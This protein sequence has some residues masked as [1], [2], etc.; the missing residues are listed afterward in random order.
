MKTKQKSTTL[1]TRAANFCERARQHGHATIQIEWRRNREG[2]Q[3]VAL[4]NQREAMARTSGG[5]Y[6]KE[7][8]ALADCLRFLGRNE[9]EAR[10]IWKKGGMGLSAI[11]G[12]LAKLGF[13]LE[14]TVTGPKLDT[15]SI[16]LTKK[17]R[18][19]SKHVRD[20]IKAHILECVRNPETDKPFEDIKDACKRMADEFERVAGDEY[21]RRRIPND[22]DRFSDFLLGLPFSFEFYDKAIAEHLNSLGINPEGKEYPDEKARHLYHYLIF[23]EMLKATN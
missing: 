8:Q 1:E 5:G 6:D 21:N 4:D 18:T 12:A 14:H 13:T 23:S 22:Q 17:Y 20:Q 10:T 11:Q 19:N 9:E 2:L 16:K 3:A 7:S 15:Y